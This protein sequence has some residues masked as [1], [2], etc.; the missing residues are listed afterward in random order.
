MLS[1]VQRVKKI[2]LFNTK[3]NGKDQLSLLQVLSRQK[4]I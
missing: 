4:K 1:S 2:K 3:A